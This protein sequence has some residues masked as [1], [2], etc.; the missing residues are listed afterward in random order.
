MTTI[1]QIGVIATELT[2]LTLLEIEQNGESK[3][4]TAE[5]AKS[6][7][8][9]LADVTNGTAAAGAIP[10][11]AGTDTSRT[12]ARVKPTNADVVITAGATPVDPVSIG[13]L[14]TTLKYWE[15]VS[16]A[17]P[18]SVYAGLNTQLL[19]WKSKTPNGTYN[20][21]LTVMSIPV[22]GGIT[23]R[24]QTEAG[25]TYPQLFNK[26]L[27]LQIKGTTGTSLTFAAGGYC[28]GEG[29]TA[30]LK[31]IGL[32]VGNN[33]KSNGVAVGLNN[34][35]GGINGCSVSVGNGNTSSPQSIGLSAGAGVGIGNQANNG[36][37]FGLENIVYGNAATGF[38]YNNLVSQDLSVAVGT[39]NTISYVAGGVQPGAA[40]GYTL[41]NSAS[42]S[43][44][45]CV[46]YAL[47][48]ALTDQGVAGLMRTGRHVSIPFVRAVT[49]VTDWTNTA[50]RT[51]GGSFLIPESVSN[52]PCKMRFNFMFK[53]SDDGTG[54]GSPSV[55]P[56]KGV[57]E[58]EVWEVTTGTPTVGLRN[59][60]G[61]DVDFL[62]YFDFQVIYTGGQA[63]L[64]YRVVSDPSSGAAATRK[65]KFDIYGEC[66]LLHFG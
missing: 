20:D 34:V 16:A 18:H 65:G 1:S 4:I 60:Q 14:G 17:H 8:T 55:L 13:L 22:K 66:S 30:Q 63:K 43:M 2:G 59:L 36:Y 45:V 24:D 29:N 23:F 39:Q 27:D 21:A 62:T 42:G 6:F 51:V 57:F 9:R 41:T 64:Q 54:S 12:V 46:P 7:F 56:R 33:A 49:G 38:G 3:Q 61:G 48:V 15:E 25:S 11:V 52:A 10:L 58:L 31:G 40:F 26:G 44:Q 35:A 19:T 28:F 32:G 5:L 47:G 53:L 37:A 50:W